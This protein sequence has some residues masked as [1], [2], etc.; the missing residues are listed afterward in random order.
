MHFFPSPEKELKRKLE[1]FR[2]NFRY[3]T[4]D[5]AY[6][7]QRQQ[8]L[9]QW[10]QKTGLDWNLARA[11]VATDAAA[12]FER[13]VRQA[14]ADKRISADEI[15]TLQ[16]LGRRLALDEH[17][18]RPLELLYDLVERKIGELLMER[19][20]Y[21]G[22]EPA[23]HSLRAEICAYH[24]PEHRQ[25]SLLARLNY[26]H[27][28]AKLLAGTLPTVTPRFT[29][30]TGEVCHFEGEVR[31]VEAQQPKIYAGDG[32]LVVTSH[33]VMVLAKVGG[34]SAIWRESLGFQYTSADL[35]TLM[36]PS[37]VV[38]LFCPNAQYV[39]TL[40]LGA[41]RRY[42]PSQQQPK[43]PGKRLPPLEG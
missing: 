24:L 28:L 3:L 40:L 32:W 43:R 42:Q 14:I 2:A 31:F 5:G 22:S 20:A 26:Q 9:F 13:T 21:L 10:C 23:V 18:T 41:K 4:S 35:L 30:D 19:A 17:Y 11:Y 15:S 25:R 38:A 6:P 27:E 1:M 39:C 7:P 33:R 8:R 36:L 34:F 37:R 29:L 12:L 16:Q